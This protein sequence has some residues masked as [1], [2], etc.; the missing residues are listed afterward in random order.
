MIVST[1]LSGDQASVQ[2]V[3]R[4]RIGLESIGGGTFDLV[5]VPPTF[6][7]ESHKGHKMEALGLLYKDPPY[8][9]L[10]HWG[11]SIST[12][13]ELLR[14]RS[15]TICLPSGVMS[16][17]RMVAVSLRC[18]SWRVFCVVR[19]SSQKSCHVNEPCI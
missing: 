13:S 6:N 16:N 5:S 17:V 1:A 10:R 9:E 11:R 2:A 14:K 4:C 19:S 15:N 18:V 3:R 7:V 12:I 8:S